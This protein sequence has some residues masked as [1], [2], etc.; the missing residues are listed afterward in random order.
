MTHENT[1]KIKLLKLWELLKRET[2]ETN[3]MDT[4]EIIEKLSKEGIEVDRKILYSDIDTLNKFGFEVLKDRSRRNRYYVMDRSFDLPEV[5]ILMDAVQGSAFVTEKK[6]EELIDKISS[7]A[8]SKKGE[9]LKEKVV[10]FGS[11]KSE[12]EAILYS[13]DTIASAIEHKN[14]ISFNYFNLDIR[15][16]KSYR[17][18]KDDPTSVRQYKVNPVAT[19]FAN[20]QYY[21][22]CYDD[23]HTGLAN[24][25]I[26]RMEKVKELDES[27]RE[28]KDIEGIDL[29]ERN[30][31]MFGM[32]GG[33]TQTVSLEA[34]KT[35]LDVIF[36]KFGSRVEMY[37]NKDG[38]LICK[39]EVQTGPMFI[40]WCCSFDSRL[41]VVSP[42]SAVN[43]VK[44]H[45]QKTLEQYK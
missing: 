17:M 3:P 4:V 12:N 35:L 18:C 43:A 41:R 23:K 39:V 19:V 37:E 31:Q 29:A 25:R 45:L 44:S 21:L 30:R 7:L 20:D 36:D 38:K 6:T 32:F 11:V 13:V 42:P 16:E 5:R 15:R 28:N 27:I 26:D 2:D 40:A 10:R 14:K 9:I 34:D 22:V 24:Y 8:G 1:R 33:E